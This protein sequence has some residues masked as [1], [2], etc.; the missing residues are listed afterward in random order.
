MAPGPPHINRRFL[1]KPQSARSGFAALSFVLLMAACQDSMVPTVVGNASVA[2]QQDETAN[3]VT[4]D[5]AVPHVSTLAANAGE[6]VSLFVRERVRSDVTD[7]P[8]EAVLMVHG[9][10]VAV[11]AAGELR[12]QDYDW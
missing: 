1:M 5:H 7:R 12:Y 9:R 10:S 3:V 2:A 4:I 11:L 6:T 8:R